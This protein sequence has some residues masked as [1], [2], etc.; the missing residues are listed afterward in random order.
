[1][2]LIRTLRNGKITELSCR[3]L[4]DFECHAS[5]FNILSEA[6]SLD[7]WEGTELPDLAAARMEAC[8]ML[9]H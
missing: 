2:L 6:G 8:V 5:N 7:D 1:M 4:K 9:A 3:A